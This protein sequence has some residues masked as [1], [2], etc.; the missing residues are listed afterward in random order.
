M[1][2]GTQ[3]AKP[4]HGP[5]PRGPRGPRPRI[6]NPGKLI[7]RLMRYTLKNYAYLLYM[8]FL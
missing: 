5:G 8:N 7:A 3:N 6:K 1:P 2:A 4:V